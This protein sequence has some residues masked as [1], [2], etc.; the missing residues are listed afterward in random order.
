MYNC[1]TYVV[2]GGA[3][4]ATGYNGKNKTRIA[5]GFLKNVNRRSG[6]FPAVSRPRPRAVFLLPD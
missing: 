4:Y 3:L 1:N 2:Y 6:L 5:A